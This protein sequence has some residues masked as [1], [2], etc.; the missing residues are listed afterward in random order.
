MSEIPY[1]ERHQQL[2]RTSLFEYSKYAPWNKR[3]KVV[4]PG[5]IYDELHLDIV[6][7]WAS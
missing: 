3:S 1:S 2:K 6:T 5:T 4:D 7:T